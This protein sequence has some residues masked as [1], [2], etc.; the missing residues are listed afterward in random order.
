MYGEDL[1]W[2]FRIRSAG[3]RIMYVPLTQIIH[4]KGESSKR[5]PLQ[6]RRLFYEAM[7][8]FVR[9]HF[10]KGTGLLPSWA[11]VAAVYV[12]AGVS[13]AAA[14]LRRFAWPLFDLLL[15]TLSFACA[16]YLRFGELFPW[17]PFLPVHIVYSSVWLI[18]L[19]A[20]GCYTKHHLSGAKA[21]SGVSAGWLVNSSLTFFFKQYAFS[22]AVILAAGGIKLLV[23]PAWRL[24]LKTAVRRHFAVFSRL[25][26]KY[27]LHR[28]T[29]IV[30]DAKAGEKI[31]NRLRPRVDG[32]Y[33]VAGIVLPHNGDAPET[34]AG[35]PVV[36]F[37]DALPSVIRRER[38]QEVIFATEN[39]PYEKILGAMADSLGSQISFKMVPDHLDVVIGKATIDYL[40]DIPFV[41]LDYRLHQK[42]FR[43]VKRLFDVSL[44][45]TLLL[46]GTPVYL[47]WKFVRRIPFQTVPLHTDRGIV[48]VKF[49]QT[50]SNLKILPALPAVLRGRLSFVGRPIGA[51]VEGEE[52]YLRLMPAGLTGLEQ[53]DDGRLTAEERRRL[54]LYYLKNYSPLLDL[55]ILLKTLTMRKR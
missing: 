27:L 55:Q 53:I 23:L 24:L 9:K 41:D 17:R 33:D 3:Y 37:L 43:T 10:K 16:V 25:F 22:R 8:L 14:L 34:V 36:G 30:G 29:L 11:L 1:D 45:A 39:L 6:Q 32:R 49:F 4:F 12:S 46:A 28:R 18:T 13:L 2:C 19:A 26:G 31:I 38:V 50:P 54:E 51:G 40:D 47:W 20:H 52:E 15:M 7:R 21:A 42:L 44:A 5:S 48:Q 35:V